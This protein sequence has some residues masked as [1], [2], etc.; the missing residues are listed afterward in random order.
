MATNISS[1][2]TQ[3]SF[4]PELVASFGKTVLAGS[5]LWGGYHIF[6][7]LSDQVVIML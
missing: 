2:R 6:M 5:S 4:R 1:G 7:P 3:T